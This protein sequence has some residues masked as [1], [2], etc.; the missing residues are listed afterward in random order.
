MSKLPYTSFA[1]IL[2]LLAIPCDEA[3][4][5]TNEAA[6]EPILKASLALKIPQHEVIKTLDGG[7]DLL[8]AWANYTGAFALLGFA[9]HLVTTMSTTKGDSLTKVTPPIKLMLETFSQQATVF[10]DAANKLYSDSVSA[11]VVIYPLFGAAKPS[12]DPITGLTA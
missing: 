10:A 4:A 12:Y 8:K 11:S 7:A 3:S 9:P 5:V 2:S 6:L 1:D